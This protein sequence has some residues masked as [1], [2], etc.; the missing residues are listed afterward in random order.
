MV[1]VC[2]IA[3][4]SNGNC[5]YIGTE[6]EAILV[7]AGISRRQ[8][9]KRMKELRLDISRVKSVFISHEHSDHIRGLRVLCDMHGIDAYLTRDT[10]HKAHRNYHPKTAH[11]FNAGDIINVGG[12]KVHTF[13][14]Q[15]DAI[16]PVS[17]R[18]EVEGLSVGVM[19]DIGAVCNNLKLHLE[20]CHIAFLESNYDEQLL[21]E[22]P[23]PYHLKQR[24]KSDKG[25]LSNKQAVDLVERL[26][27]ADLNTIFLSHI[28]ADNNRVEIALK[29]FEHLS[30]KYRILPTNRYAPSELVT[31]G[32]EQLALFG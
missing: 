18:V 5:Y 26:E 11:V 30:K 24:V 10:L 19:T 12:F 7:D 25:H 6:K 3:S 22:G 1:K 13:T 8:I 21:E 27:K 32:E 28:S 17:F 15:H 29:A 9:M 2:A 31:V 4:G 16:D 14:K 20:Q 23:Y